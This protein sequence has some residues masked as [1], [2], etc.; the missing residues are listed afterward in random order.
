MLQSRVVHKSGKWAGAAAARLQIELIGQQVA[1]GLVVPSDRD[2]KCR[3]MRQPGSRPPREC[4]A[5][6]CSGCRQ[7]MQAGTRWRMQETP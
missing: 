2:N 5:G 6:K 7:Q 4:S 1:T 3:I